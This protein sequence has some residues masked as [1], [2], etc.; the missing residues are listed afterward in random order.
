VDL[1][2]T[3][4]AQHV[5]EKIASILESTA[6]TSALVQEDVLTANSVVSRSVQS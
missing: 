2:C 3:P 1:A 6:I 5:G 4:S